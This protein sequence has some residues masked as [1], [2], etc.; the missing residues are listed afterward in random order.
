MTAQNSTYKLLYFDARGAGEAIRY[1]FA[2]A[3]VQYEDERIPYDPTL[4]TDKQPAWFPIRDS[5]PFHQV[6]VLEVDGNQL[7]QSIAISRF[8]G[9]RF[10]LAGKDEFEQATVDGLADY[11][12]DM[13][14]QMRE[15]FYGDDE[16][17]RKRAHDKYFG[18]TIHEFLKVFEE[19]LERNK[20]GSGFLVGSGPTWADLRVVAWIGLLDSVD[21][22]FLGKYREYPRLTA[23]V[24]RVNNLMGIKEWIAKRPNTVF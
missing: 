11:L 7:G 3:G 1:I 2:Y 19:Q 21:H 10:G 15:V 4:T 24:D 5:T 8:L 20:E 14:I 6:P 12:S 9:R 22:G 13:L 17:T 23:L 18:E 16:K